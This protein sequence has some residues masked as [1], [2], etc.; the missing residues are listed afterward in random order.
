MFYD[1]YNHIFKEKQK[2]KN[3]KNWQNIDFTNSK[4]V[5]YEIEI[6]IQDYFKDVKNPSK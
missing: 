4:K 2:L 3:F 6:F 1:I 5:K